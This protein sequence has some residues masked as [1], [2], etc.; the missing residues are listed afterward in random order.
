M[1][2]HYCDV[3]KAWLPLSSYKL[4]NRGPVF[5]YFSQILNQPHVNL[6]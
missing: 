2:N 4:A 3:I 1:E 6:S 5:Q